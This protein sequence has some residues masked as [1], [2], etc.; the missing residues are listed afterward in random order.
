[1]GRFAGRRRGVLA[2]GLN[3]VAEPAFEID[4]LQKFEYNST[5]L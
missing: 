5:K 1:L 3:S 4:F 2:P